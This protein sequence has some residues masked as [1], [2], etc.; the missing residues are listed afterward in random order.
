MR[1]TL[2]LVL[3][4]A[5][6]ANGGPPP[7]PVAASAV[8]TASVADAKTLIRTRCQICHSIQHVTQQ[9]LTAAQWSA[10]V[11]KMLKWGAPLTP[12]EGA[13]IAAKLAAEQPADAPDPP[14]RRVPTPEG[15]RAAGVGE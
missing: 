13:A 4:G 10:T 1:A 8:A 15:A 5:C 11:E 2:L 12:E 14:T 7:A 3:L 9:R 6:E